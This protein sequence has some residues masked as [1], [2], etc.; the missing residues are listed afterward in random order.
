MDGGMHEPALPAFVVA[1]AAL[2]E[3][4]ALRDASPALSTEVPIGPFE[5]VSKIADN[6][7]SPSQPAAIDADGSALRAIGEIAPI[8]I[9]VNDAAGNTVYLN[10]II[11]DIL[12]QSMEEAIERW[13]EAI[14]PD[15]R[16]RVVR[17]WI[18][19][20]DAGQIFRSRH[21][22]LRSNGTTVWADVVAIPLLDPLGNPNGTVG[23]IQDITEQLDIVGEHAGQALRRSEQRYR[24][25]LDTAQEGVWLRDGN[26]R[27]VFVN[28]RMSDMLG[29]TAEEMM[30]RP[31]YDFMDAEARAEA[32]RRFARR[33][34]GECQQ[35]DVRYKHKDGSDVWTIVSASPIYD[36]DGEFA[37]VFGM[38][39]DITERKRQEET[40]WRQAYHDALTGLPNRALFEDRLSQLIMM[41]DRQDVHL[42]IMFIDLDRFKQVNDTLGHDVGDQ[43]L[44]IVAERISACL[45]SGDTVAR[46]GGDEFTAL[47]PGITQPEDV[48]KV[49]QKV[50][51][52][53]AQPIEVAGHELYAPGSIGISM[54][55]TDG[56]DVQTLLKHADIAMY[57]AKEQGGGYSMYTQ[58]MNTNAME[59]LVL[60]SSLRKALQ[61]KEFHLVYQPQVDLDSGEITA[62]EAL[63]RWTHPDL[64]VIQP[65][66]FIPLA[67]ET[68]MIVPLGEWVLREA[69]RQA[70]EWRAAGHPRRVSV[71]ISARQF[72]QPGL[73]DIVASVLVETGLESRWLDLELTESTIMQNAESASEII[74]G[75][76]ALGVRLALDDFGTGYSSLSYLR[77][78]RFDV[79][80]IDR[81]FVADLVDDAV[82]QAVVRAI[83]DMSRSLGLDVVA[84]GVET[85]AQLRALKALGCTTAQ[86]F[87]FCR[88]AKPA[89]ISVDARALQTA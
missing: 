61:R 81:S 8:G 26:A 43:L 46:M 4:S 71:N 50:L 88:P 17:E 86:G 51:E 65:G 20:K 58:S 3:L 83:I 75:L 74:S 55:P 41:S 24:Q 15:D 79:L 87:L 53:L 73:A 45:R 89:D 11:L 80:K 9:F 13:N 54:Y 14:H 57:R 32:E 18:D 38:I 68:G 82:N 77:Q 85:N 59:H 33:R 35:H 19:R 52:S 66:Q 7:S 67:E 6:G 21:R 72:A 5:T 37:G 70:E 56:H 78:F 64:G 25:M 12:D 48:I 69:C 76:R 60:E 47:L 40:V 34:S 63:C 30:G 62:V 23:T 84:E 29:Y 31:V 10:S 36:D 2:E 22:F 39:T 27:T 42:A 28:R 16:D 44:K 1:G 49:A